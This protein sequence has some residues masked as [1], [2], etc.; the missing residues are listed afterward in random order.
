MDI[1]ILDLQKN[2]VINNIKF[3]KGQKIPDRGNLITIDGV[4]NI[5]ENINYNISDGGVCDRLVIL[6]KRV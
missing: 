6:V 4:T 2:V 3:E 1:S 5:V